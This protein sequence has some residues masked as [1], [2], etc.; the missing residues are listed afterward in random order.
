MFEKRQYAEALKSPHIAITFSQHTGAVLVNAAILKTI[1]LYNEEGVSINNANPSVSDGDVGMFFASDYPPVSP[2]ITPF[3]S[4]R[5]NT[6]NENRLGI[7]GSRRKDSNASGGVGVIVVKG[8]ADDHSLETKHSLQTRN[9]IYQLIESFKPTI[10]ASKGRPNTDI[11]VRFRESN[12]NPA[13]GFFSESGTPPSAVVTTTT[14]AAAGEKN[15]EATTNTTA[16]TPQPP[17]PPHGS[18]GI[19]PSS[20]K[21]DHI[22]LHD[23]EI[24]I[25]K[26]N[27]S[28]ESK[29]RA[30]VIFQN[31]TIK[32]KAY[33]PPPAQHPR[34]HLQF[35]RITGRGVIVYFDDADVALTLSAYIRDDPLPFLLHAALNGSMLA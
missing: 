2:Q 17:P 25:V 6:D 5:Y 28:L 20:R 23:K 30:A 7:S 34:N 9:H 19:K 21:N 4:Y 33:P 35:V 27:K 13:F 32:C 14:A 3:T 18:Y 16:L 15:R 11:Q 22:L 26:K 1:E 12:T 29:N 24:G 10:L 8:G 31:V